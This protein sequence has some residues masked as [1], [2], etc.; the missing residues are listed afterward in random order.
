MPKKDFILDKEE[1]EI[2]QKV[3]QEKA[4]KYES[5][6]LRYIL[7]EYQKGEGSGSVQD[8]MR[9]LNLVT[10]IIRDIEKNNLQLMDAFNTVLI[11]NDIETCIPVELF[12]SPVFEG[13]KKYMKERLAKMKQNKDYQNKKRGI[14]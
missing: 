11:S 5:Q 9:Q 13:S 3:K 7:R 4:F 14:K 1:I 6:A 8:L 12:E 2:I 10:A